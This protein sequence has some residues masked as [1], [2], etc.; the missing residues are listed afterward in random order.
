MTK[1]AVYSIA[2]NEAKHIARWAE[3]AK[4]ADVLLILDTGSEDDTV[5]IAKE[6]GVTVHKK[7]YKTFKFDEARNDALNLI[8]DDVDFCFSVDVD[9]ILH[10]GWREQLEKAIE[11]N[12]N[13]TQFGYLFIN[14]KLEDGTP[15]QSWERVNIHARHGSKWVWPIHEMLEVTPS[16]RASSGVVSEHLPD[17]TKPRNYLP[18]LEQA[19]KDLPEDTRMSFYYGRELFYVQ[20]LEECAVELKRYLDLGGWSYERSEAMVM[21]A[22]CEPE[23][24]EVWLF[25]ACAETPDRR[26]PF[27][28]LAE[29]YYSEQR[30]QCGLGMANRAVSMTRKHP[31]YITEDKAWNFFIYDIAALC[32]HNAGAHVLAVEYGKQALELYP[33]D[34][35]LSDNLSWYLKAL[36]EDSDTP[37]ASP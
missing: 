6:S 34:Q 11:E 32:A 1:I 4:D 30:W 7:K 27:V 13:A 28:E 12:P 15:L 21:I 33:G 9:E 16:I 10:E 19:V 3:S 25:R 18:M 14:S 29:L 5:K 20:R 22:K 23:N 37:V 26:E 2:K 17:R 24:A 8:P 31:A 36:G 35:R